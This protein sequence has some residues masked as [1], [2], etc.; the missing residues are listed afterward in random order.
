M[1]RRNLSPAICELGPR[2]G[3]GLGAG[4]AEVEPGRALHGSA[5][6][7]WYS[8]PL[9]GGKRRSTPDLHL[10]AQGRRRSV[11]I[12]ANSDSVTVYGHRHHRLGVGGVGLCWFEGCFE[13]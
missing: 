7:A 6:W 3:F 8:L 1:A 13:A 5:V 2:A 9:G 11:I 12:P 4:T 10:W